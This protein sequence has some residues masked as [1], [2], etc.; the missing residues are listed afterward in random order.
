MAKQSTN[1]LSY[2]FHRPSCIV[3]NPSRTY[4]C[5]LGSGSVC[6]KTLDGWASE[7]SNLDTFV[8]CVAQVQVLLPSIDESFGI[9]TD[10]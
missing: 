10:I 4:Y 7:I 5:R 6:L 2:L 1:K 8:V 9:Y 3:S